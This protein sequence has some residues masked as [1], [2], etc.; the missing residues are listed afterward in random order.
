MGLFDDITKSSAADAGDL[1]K[2]A[3]HC[4]ANKND[5]FSKCVTDMLANMSQACS[6]EENKQARQRIND[7]AEN[8]T[9]V[10]ATLGGVAGGIIG[11]A[12]GLWEGIKSGDLI[13]AGVSTLYGAS[14]GYDVGKIIGNDPTELI[15]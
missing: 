3:Q 10:C 12:T 7:K 14:K 5:S 9:G 13:G 11:C 4:F 2:A 15:K 8:A 1:F 6:T